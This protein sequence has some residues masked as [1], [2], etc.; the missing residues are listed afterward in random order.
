MRLQKSFLLF[1]FVVLGS[2]AKL[3]SQTVYIAETGKKY[4]TKSCP[5]VK[6]N[7][8]A[9]ELS[10]AQKK[11]YTA[12]PSCGADKIILKQKEEKEDDKKKVSK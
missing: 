4:H 6:S 8:K 10:E 1:V 5:A 9:I 11:G 7:R 12:C 3:N 2:F